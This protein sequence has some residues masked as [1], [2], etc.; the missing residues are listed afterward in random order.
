MAY[1]LLIP[2]YTVIA[3][4]AN[5]P[6]LA[7]V[8]VSP[9]FKPTQGDCHIRQLLAFAV[10]NMIYETSSLYPK[11]HTCLFCGACDGQAALVQSAC[12]DEHMRHNERYTGVVG[13]CVWENL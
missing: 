9:S 6:G 4:Y 2:F 13:G 10:R 1:T 8:F 12:I 7:D 3:G 5:D 11:A